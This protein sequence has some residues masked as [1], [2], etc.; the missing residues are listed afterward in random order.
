MA[1]ITVDRKAENCIVVASGANCL[2]SIET[3][4]RA[5]DKIAAADF[6]LMQLEIPMNIIEYVAGK[7][8]AYGTK[9][10]LNPAPAAALSSE[11]LSKL[12]LITPNRTECLL[13]TGVEIS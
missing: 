7:A 11:L 3:I 8:T 6:L 1:L 9:I 12:F 5:A 4:Y 10:I 13:L 2:L